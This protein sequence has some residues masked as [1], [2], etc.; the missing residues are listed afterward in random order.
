MAGAI[1]TLTAQIPLGYVGENESREVRI[2]IGPYV[3]MWPGMTPQ[4]VARRPGEKDVYP[5]KSRREGNVLVWTITH[6]DTAIDGYGEVRVVMMGEEGEVGKSPI[7]QTY[8][9]GGMEGEMRQDPPEAARPWVNEVI[10]AAQDAK[11]AAK[12][13]EEIAEALAGGGGDVNSGL[14][15]PAVTP[16]DDGKVL[17]VIEGKWAAKTP[18][19]SGVQFETDDTLILEDGILRVNTADKMEEDNT[20][21]ITSAAVFT[22]VG[23]INALLAT[24]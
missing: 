17:T 14:F 23:N 18:E 9:R 24:I 20:L 13:A 21:P 15:L 2:D 19:E 8:I 22:E 11:D 1:Y 16:E 7:A 10:E 12:R 5:C 3:R 4:L 6:S